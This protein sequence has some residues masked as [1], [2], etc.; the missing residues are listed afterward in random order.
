MVF[1]R[2][3]ENLAKDIY[4]R[5]QAI[6]NMLDILENNK[7]TKM[8]TK[9]EEKKLN[10]RFFSLSVEGKDITVYYQITTPE[11]IRTM[12]LTAIAIGLAFGLM[13]GGV[14]YI[15]AANK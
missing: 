10:T 9:E 13:F 7:E 1:N 15:T 6:S 11:D 4:E 14:I 12:W 8:V 2:K 3:W 5:P